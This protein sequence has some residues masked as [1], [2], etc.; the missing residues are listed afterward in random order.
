MADQFQ[1]LLCEVCGKP[2]RIGWSQ[3]PG[4]TFSQA[5]PIF[6]H[7]PMGAGMPV[8]QLLSFE[9]LRDGKWVA[10]TPTTKLP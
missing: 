9:E 2:Y 8:P 1:E 5:I 3:P 7:C 6:S 4:Y 10:V